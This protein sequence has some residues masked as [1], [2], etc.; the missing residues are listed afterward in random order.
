MSTQRLHLH[1]KLFSKTWK[2]KDWNWF[3]GGF[4]TF[5]EWQ[6]RPKRQTQSRI[7]PKVIFLES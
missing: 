4:T 6:P 1:C 7:G 2:F 5:I 3:S